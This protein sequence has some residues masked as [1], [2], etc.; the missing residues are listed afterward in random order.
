MGQSTPFGSTPFRPVAMTD[1]EFRTL[2]HAMTTA[3]RRMSPDQV[4][5]LADALYDIRRSKRRRVDIHQMID[6]LR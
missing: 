5:T 1:P 4:A 6:A 3:A 2:L